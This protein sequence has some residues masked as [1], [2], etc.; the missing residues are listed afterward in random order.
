MPPTS[1]LSEDLVIRLLMAGCNTPPPNAAGKLA[2]NNHAIPNQPLLDSS[3]NDTLM[4]WVGAL[5]SPWPA[6]LWIT[7]DSLYHG[8][9]T[10]GV[11][12]VPISPIASAET[13]KITSQRSPLFLDLRPIR[14][15]CTIT[16]K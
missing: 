16:I 14:P 3:G 12:A 1:R 4:F 6:R 15:P 11:S 10:R 2:I 8:T 5:S 7:L 9:G 13:P